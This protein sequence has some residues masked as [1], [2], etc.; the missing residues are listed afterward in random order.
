MENK[1]S[2]NRPVGNQKLNASI[3]AEFGGAGNC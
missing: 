2:S 3:I 1:L